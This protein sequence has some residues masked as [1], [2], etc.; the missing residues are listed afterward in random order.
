MGNVY[1]AI[2]MLKPVREVDT[3]WWKLR[4]RP[5][6]RKTI[7]AYW[8][9]DRRAFGLGFRAYP[10]GAHNGWGRSYSGATAVLFLG[11]L[12][13]NFW[14]CW[15]FVVHKDGPLDM[16]QPKPLNI[17]DAPTEPSR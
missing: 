16:K 1:D 17:P 13:F 2:Y 8:L 14:V 3:G 11:P 5:I 9:L 7:S 12:S 4:W 15:N 6:W 10:S